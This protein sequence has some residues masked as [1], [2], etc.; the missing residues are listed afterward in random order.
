[1]QNEFD[2]LVIGSLN[3]DLVVTTPRFPKPGET[4]RGTGFQH[5]CGGK[6]ANQAY[7]AATL[8]A[9]VAMMGRVGADSFGESL[10]HNLETRG[11]DTAL[12]LNA[13]GVPTG[14]ALITVDEEGENQIIIVP[15]ANAQLTARCL[16]DREANAI[17]VAFLHL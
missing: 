10:R 5:H 4:L 12:T 13:P 6:G 8:G 2:I 14:T 7:A 15:G 3:M 1:M 9:K 17:Q 11:V 16:S